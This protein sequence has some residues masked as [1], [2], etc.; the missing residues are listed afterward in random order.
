MIDDKEIYNCAFSEQERRDLKALIEER[1]HMR[2]IKETAERYAKWMLTLPP[3][4]L[5]AYVACQTL[6]SKIMK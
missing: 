3:M 5:G 1:S 4:A 2:Y 6:L